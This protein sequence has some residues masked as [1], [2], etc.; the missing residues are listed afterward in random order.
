MT[1]QVEQDGRDAAQAIERAL[2]TPKPGS[3][4]QGFYIVHK[5]FKGKSFKPG[6]VW[7]SIGDGPVAEWDDVLEVIIDNFPLDEESPSI[8]T[9]RVWE[10]GDG[11][12][13]DCTKDAIEATMAAIYDRW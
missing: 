9:L 2:S 3:Y 13:E 11:V 10:C 12:I 7:G 1:T 6:G 4:P 8:Y 5:L